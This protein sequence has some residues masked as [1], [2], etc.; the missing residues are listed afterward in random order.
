MSTEQS[1]AFPAKRTGTIVVATWLIG[2]GLVFLVRQLLDLPWS[3]A[4]PLFL[5]LVGGASIVSTLVST[6]GRVGWWRGAGLI[7]PLA[8]IAVG[9]ILLLNATGVTDIDLI[10]FAADWWPLILIAVGV[11]LLIGSVV[12]GVRGHQERLA[13][14]LDGISEAMIKLSF[15]AGELRVAAAPP[16][17][18]VDGEFRGG[19][20]VRRS[21]TGRLE[22]AR[23]SDRG[24]LFGERLD[25]RFGISTEIP[26]DLEVS[27]GASD[28]ELDLTESLVRSLK[29]ST[30]ASS[31]TVRLPRAAGST[32]V[33]A[34]SGAASLELLVPHG[35]AARIRSEMV[36]GSTDV[37][38]RRFPRSGDLYLSPD[39]ETAEHRVEIKVEGGVGSVT[40][41]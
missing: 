25:W 32:S 17:M 3:Q 8:L 24:W 40:I 4:W 18:L 5:V 1:S 34:E 6:G 16:G 23:H 26:L 36:L 20:A 35:V 30:G 9:L 29:V 11:V 13:I 21:G 27:A 7:W 2:I 28:T 12:A 38:E 22:L 31:T 37:D 33:K 41:R 14:R 15:G 39:Y 19:V 10:G